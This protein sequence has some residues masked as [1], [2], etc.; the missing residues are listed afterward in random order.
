M[1]LQKSPEWLVEAFDGIVPDEDPRVER[2]KM[3]GFPSAF[4]SGNMFISLFQDSMVMR[5]PEEDRE[6]FLEE[7]KT[8][9]FRPAPNQ[10]MREY[11]VVPHDMVRD[12][13]AL[14]PW[15]RRSLEYAASVKPKAKKAAAKKT[16]E[17]PAAKKPAKKPAA[18]KGS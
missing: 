9:V 11:V 6:R 13:K 4:A 3:F 17:K 7:Y 2:R 16:A 18:K 1:A 5:L 15:L 14:E 10:V 12:P 8:E